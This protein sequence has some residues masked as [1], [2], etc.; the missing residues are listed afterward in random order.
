MVK[1]VAVS[2]CSGAC[3][4]VLCRLERMLLLK[5]QITLECKVFARFNFFGLLRTEAVKAMLVTL[6]RVTHEQR[7]AEKTLSHSGVQ[8]SERVRRAEQGN[9]SGLHTLRLLSIGYR[10]PTRAV[11]DTSGTIRR[12]WGTMV[13]V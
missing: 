7:R 13:D 11:H 8:L 2:G 1:G 10:L 6:G 5:T 9:L 4:F 3:G 12:L